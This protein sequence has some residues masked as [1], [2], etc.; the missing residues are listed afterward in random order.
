MDVPIVTRFWETGPIPP[1]TLELGTRL[2]AK[3]LESGGGVV[4]AETPKGGVTA[5]LSGDLKGT[6][7][8]RDMMSKARGK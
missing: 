4:V 8:R 6:N 1:P 7:E 5:A 2:P 3:G